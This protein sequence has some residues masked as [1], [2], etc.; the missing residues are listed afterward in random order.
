MESRG[1]EPHV[2]ENLDMAA[3]LAPAGVADALRAHGFSVQAN[4]AMPL[5][6]DETVP[7]MKADR[8]RDAVGTVRDGPTVLVIDTGLDSLHPDFESGQNL[9]A[10]V[11]AERTSNGVIAG[12]ID[13]VP[14]VDRSGH[15]THVA[16]IVAGSASGLGPSDPRQGQYAGAYSNGRVASFQASTDAADAE[17]IAVDLQAALEGF[18]WAMA[19]QDTYDIRVI[20][21]SWGSSGDLEADHP[22]AV[23]SLKAYASGMTVFFSAGNA[24]EEGSLNRHCLPPWVVCVAA[25]DLDQTRASYSSMGHPPSESLGAYD[26]PDL[27]APG[28]RVRSTEPT[29][30]TTGATG[31]L[32]EDGEALYGDRSGTSMAAPHA[33]AVAA[34]IQAA[35]PALSPDQVMDVLVGTTDPMAEPIHRVGA[36]YINAQSAYNLAIQTQGVRD[37]FLDG[38]GL[39]YAGPATGDAV[40]GADPVSVG[41][42]SQS[43]G[44]VDR[45]LLLDP[46]E[47]AWLLSGSWVPWAV[48]GAAV[49]LALGGIRWSRRAPRPDGARQPESPSPHG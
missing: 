37:A 13:D 49:V 19:N 22:V 2:Y 29:A 38:R 11:A 30:G 46:P 45:Q 32:S 40:F 14:I 27:T 25:G 1:L 23:A 15:G 24:G 6:L 39:K 48:L 28:T 20:T 34:L 10:N 18:E 43:G 26:H 21:N 31:L 17:E 4:E 41:Y 5:H 7:Y 47:E 44:D 3:V 9:A 42:D 12:T 8:V 36:G 16:G 33:A 35:K